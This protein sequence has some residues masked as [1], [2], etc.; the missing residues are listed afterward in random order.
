MLKDEIIIAWDYL[1]D[2]GIATEDELQLVTCI[3]GYNLDTLN[4][5]IY[6]KTGYR[7]IEQLKD[8]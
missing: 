3:I 8:V 7:S 1:I 4:K 6:A 2:N 5:V